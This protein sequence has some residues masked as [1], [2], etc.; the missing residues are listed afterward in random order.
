MRDNKTVTSIKHRPSPTIGIV[1]DEGVETNPFDWETFLYQDPSLKKYAQT[2]AIG[3]G[4]ERCLYELNPDL[5]CLSPC[6]IHARV[7]TPTEA[8]IA[9][10]QVAAQPNRPAFPVDRHLAAFFI[11]RWKEMNFID[12]RDMGKPQREVRNLAV[13]KILAGIQSHFKVKGLPHLCQWMADLCAPIISQYHNLKARAKAQ[14]DIAKAVSSGQLIKLVQVLE[15]RQALLNDECDYHAAKIEVLLIE[16]EIKEIE[17]KI[18]NRNQFVSRSQMS[19]WEMV[20]SPFIWVKN[21]HFSRQSKKHMR[22]L[23]QKSEILRETWGEGLM[24]R[25]KNMAQD[26]WGKLWAKMNVPRSPQRQGKGPLWYD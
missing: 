18:V 5:A 17:R 15:N 2:E 3:Y 19:I 4:V 9:L 12:L 25:G 24:P 20:C 22:T 11:S 14:E 13:L 10:E 7:L 23:Y 6:L 21:A 16:S 8:L 1:K 26:F